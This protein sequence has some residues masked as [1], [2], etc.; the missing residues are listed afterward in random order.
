MGRFVGALIDGKQRSYSEL[1]KAA[2]FTGLGYSWGKDAL[3]V[4]DGE[5]DNLYSPAKKPITLTTAR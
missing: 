5:L 1:L 4:V 3:R 2:E